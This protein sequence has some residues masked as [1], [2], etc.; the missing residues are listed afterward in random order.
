MQNR[1]LL[2]NLNRAFSEHPASV[3]ESYSAHLV[4]AG[5]FGWALF[6]A[7]LACFVHAVLPFAFE[8]TGSIAITELHRKMVSNRDRR[9]THR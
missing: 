9:H 6:K 8:K 3:G 1:S 2:S 7:S 4:T 5:G